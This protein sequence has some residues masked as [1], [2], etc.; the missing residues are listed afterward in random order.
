MT[1]LSQGPPAPSHWN[2]NSLPLSHWAIDPLWPSHPQVLKRPGELRASQFWDGA[3]RKRSPST[4]W[5]FKWR[6]SDQS[7][8]FRL[9]A[10][11]KTKNNKNIKICH[12]I[13]LGPLVVWPLSGLMWWNWASALAPC[14]SA[15]KLHTNAYTNAYTHK[16]QNHNH[17]YIVF[18]YSTRVA[19]FFP[20]ENWLNN[21]REWDNGMCKLWGLPTMI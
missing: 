7:S 9:K 12:S 17:A 4:G 20:Y 6:I 1:W 14:C 15:S 11:K 3:D 18:I 5:F 21:C 16:H 13:D 2:G 8:I 10:P 19:W